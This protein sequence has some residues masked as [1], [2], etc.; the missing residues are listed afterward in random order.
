MIEETTSTSTDSVPLAS[1]MPAPSVELPRIESEAE[2]TEIGLVRKVAPIVEGFP[3]RLPRADEIADLN[4]HF[5]PVLTAVALE[6]ICRR[7]NPHSAFREVVE[8]AGREA[9]QGR[10]PQ[11]DPSRRPEVLIVEST[12]PFWPGRKWGQHVE[13]WRSWVRKSGCTTDFIRTSATGGVQTNAESIV[14]ELKRQTHAPLILFSQGQGS[15]EV[16][17]ALE[18]L[19]ATAPEALAGI[20]AWVSVGGGARGLSMAAWRSRSWWR[21]TQAEL[22]LSMKGRPP[23]LMRSLSSAHPRVMRP[24]GAPFRDSTG[25]SILCVSVVGLALPSDVPQSMWSEFQAFSRWIGPNDGVASFQDQVL[26]V[27]Y[28]LPILGLTAAPESARLGPWLAG[29]CSVLAQKLSAPNA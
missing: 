26:G 6:Q 18:H 24:L 29:I 20:G 12:D 13:P 14:R 8:A 22:A 4:A 19:A 7:L 1:A 23:Q 16:R 11:L 17:W 10:A 15:M 3:D 25:R 28:V 9:L 27:G 21:L 5:G 2:L